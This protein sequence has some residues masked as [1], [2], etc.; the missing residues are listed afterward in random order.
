M[1]HRYTAAHIKFITENVVGHSRK[2]LTEMVN[3]QFGLELSLSQ[4]TG[5]IKNNKLSSGID[6]TFKPGN[7]PFNKGKKGFGGW[8]PTQFKKGNKPL[9]YRPVGSERVSV[10][11]YVEIKVADPGKWRHKHVVTW[12][13]ENG[14]VPKGKVLL[15]L[16]GNQLNVSVDNL[17][18]ITRSQLARLN[19]LDL[20]SHDADLTKTGI[21]ITDVYQKIGE[22]KTK[23]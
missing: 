5:F 22:R 7:I 20:I 8:E 10:D 19:N 3:S 16:D 14:P 17:Q 18:L 4:I 15:F 13:E 23:K 21:I 12:E 1:V 9:N 2:E 6:C 11:G